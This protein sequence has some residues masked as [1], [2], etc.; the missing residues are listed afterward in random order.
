MVVSLFGARSWS[1]ALLLDRVGGYSLHVF[2]AF[3]TNGLIGKA[4][5]PLEP[6]VGLHRN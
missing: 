3:H 1:H 6:Y 2:I 5:E 4:Q